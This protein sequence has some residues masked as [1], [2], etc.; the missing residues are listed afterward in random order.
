MPDQREVWTHQLAVQS[1]VQRG[2]GRT[3]KVHGQKDGRNELRG[4][5]RNGGALYAPVENKDVDRVEHGIECGAN[6]HAIHG[7]TRMAVRTR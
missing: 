5:G 1:H 2:L 7:H 4:D 3:D 6:E